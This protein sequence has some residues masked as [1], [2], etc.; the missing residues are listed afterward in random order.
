MMTE[1]ERKNLHRII[2]NLKYPVSFEAADSP[3]TSST[4]A[5][6]TSTGEDVTNESQREKRPRVD[7]AEWADDAADVGL[8]NEL[9]RYCAAHFTLET[10]GCLNFGRDRHP[11]S[12]GFVHWQGGSSAFQHQ[13]QPVSAHSAPQVMS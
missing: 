3:E 8:T 12:R 9:E 7:F 2:G 13:V 1:T 6:R 4:T 5:P 10:T 11:P